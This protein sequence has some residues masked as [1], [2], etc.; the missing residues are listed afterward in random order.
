M[1]KPDLP[2]SPPGLHHGF[3]FAELRTQSGLE[4]LDRLYLERL[5][6]RDAALH[7]RLLAYRQNSGG[8]SPTDT[9]ELLLACAPLLDEIVAELF[10]IQPELEARRQQTLAHDP[11][12][13][14]K[15]EFV[16]RRARRRLAKKEVLE[17]FAELDAWLTQ[18]LAQAGPNN[19]DRELAVAQ[20]GLKWL[21][22]EKTN[23]DAVEKLTRWCVCALTTPEGRRVIHDWSGFRLPQPREHHKLVP[24]VPLPNDP[25]GRVQGP[26]GHLR[27][28]DGFGLTDKR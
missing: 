22:D 12:F 28:R 20:L 21:Q 14:F 8:L 5:R 10:G 16:L 7:D 17:N 4:R 23:V 6:A 25:L 11:V 26:P 15:K 13:H 1:S 19:S 3:T 18:T 2:A 9:S 27:R 24:I